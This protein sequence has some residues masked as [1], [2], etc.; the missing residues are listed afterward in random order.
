MAAC[1]INGETLHA[2]SGIS[3]SDIDQARIIYNG[4]SSSKSTAGSG[5]NTSNGS[6]SGG[7]GKYFKAERCSAKCSLV[8]NR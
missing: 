1:N 8:I 3:S 5:R 4:S 7:S 2:W 6:G